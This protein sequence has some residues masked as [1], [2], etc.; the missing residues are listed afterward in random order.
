[1]ARRAPRARPSRRQRLPSPACLTGRQTERRR[2]PRWPRL[3]CRGR[4]RFPRG[5]SRSFIGATRQTT[6]LDAPDAPG[7]IRTRVAATAP[8]ASICAMTRAAPSTGPPLCASSVTHASRRSARRSTAALAVMLS[9]PRASARATTAQRPAR[10][11]LVPFAP[12]AGAG[13]S[14]TTSR[15][16]GMTSRPPPPHASEA[17]GDATSSRT[18]RRS[19]RGSPRPAD[20]PGGRPSDHLPS[21]C[22]AITMRCTCAVPS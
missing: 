6:A 16:A 20:L 2:G 9:I 11:V 13:V 10:D 22:R 7:S 17:S 15:D 14:A 5:R 3:R 1:M 4:R 21:T 18:T 8:V 12:W 19:E